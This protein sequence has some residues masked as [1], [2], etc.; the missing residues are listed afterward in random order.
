MIHDDDDGSCFK[1]CKKNYR[2]Y[3]NLIHTIQQKNGWSVAGI[4]II[5]ISKAEY[6][7][8]A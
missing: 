1:I 6:G 5:L 2:I 3:K 8:L 4:L 7:A